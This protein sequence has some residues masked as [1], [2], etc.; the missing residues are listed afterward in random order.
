M[1]KIRGIYKI[2]NTINNNIYIGSSKDTKRRKYKHFY[3]LSI[4]THRNPVLQ[5]SY[6]KYGKDAFV[7]QLVEEVPEDVPLWPIEKK[8][9]DLYFDNQNTCFN[10]TT[11][12]SSG[13][14]GRKHTVE[15][16]EKMKQNS[17]MK[18][19]KRS[20]EFCEH[21]RKS[22]TGIKRSPATRL[23][24]G[25]AS[26]GRIMPRSAVEYVASLNRGRKKTPEQVE[27][28]ACKLRG[29]LKSPEHC[30]A[31]SASKIGK[32]H[33]PEV[34]RR[35]EE[36]K[37][38]NRESGKV[39]PWKHTPETIAKGVATRLRNKLLKQLLDKKAA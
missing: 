13:M 9:I 26:K 3:E 34:V 8:Y 33:D 29:K 16:K 20:P 39:I 10:I 15:S 28:T 30:A 18:G 38:K 27:K 32:K 12:E 5:A 36:T 1:S 22:L 4:G 6:N 25:N 19:K 37:R 35:R 11:N 23:A 17:A 2:V 21:I 7:F 31:I 14:D 24:I